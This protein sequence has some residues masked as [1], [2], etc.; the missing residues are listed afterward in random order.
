MFIVSPTKGGYRGDVNTA[1]RTGRRE[2]FYDY[3]DSYNKSLQADNNTY[4]FNQR[5]VRDT[6]NNYILKNNMAQDA[7]DEAYDFVKKSDDIASAQLN[8]DVNNAYRDY[9]YSND[10]VGTLGGSKAKTDVNNTFNSTEKSTIDLAD[11][12]QFGAE[13]QRLKSLSSIEQHNG[14]ILQNKLQNTLYRLNDKDGFTKTKIATKIKELKAGGDQRSSSEIEASLRSDP[15]YM[16]NVEAE[17]QTL[18]ED[19]NS[20]YENINRLTQKTRS[21]GQGK[22]R[23]SMVSFDL[24]T[25]ENAEIAKFLKSK[26]PPGQ[27]LNFY[28]EG[29]IIG[30]PDGSFIQKAAGKFYKLRFHSIE[31]LNNFKAQYYNSATQQGTVINYGNTNVTD[32]GE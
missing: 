22:P 5:A 29:D 9:V 21:S 12:R 10:L 15:A 1:F 20:A 3:I 25:D 16:Q 7:R 8:F 6:A 2:A 17:R 19:T 23:Y 14:L 28:K 13:L 4:N 27:D 24:N 32:I 30:L 18:L 11:T 31:D 26:V